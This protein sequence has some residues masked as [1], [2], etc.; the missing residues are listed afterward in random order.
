MPVILI[1]SDLYN[2]GLS[3]KEAFVKLKTASDH[4]ESIKYALEKV[5]SDSV[6]LER[7]DVITVNGEAKEA[8]VSIH[9]DS[10][11]GYKVSYSL[12]GQVE[13]REMDSYK[14][15]FELFQNYA[16]AWFDVRWVLYEYS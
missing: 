3:K 14:T 9:G 15:A 11:S 5:Y 10:D 12:G 6:S 4:K 7:S 8:S 2:E 13:Y 16:L 1:A